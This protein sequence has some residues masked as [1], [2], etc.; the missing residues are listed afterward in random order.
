MVQLSRNKLFRTIN[1]KSNQTLGPWNIIPGGLK[2]IQKEQGAFCLLHYSRHKFV[3]LCT[4]VLVINT[5]IYVFVKTN[6]SLF[7][8]CINF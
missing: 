2:I 6:I 8:N 3:C 5:K 7:I 1:L 4:T